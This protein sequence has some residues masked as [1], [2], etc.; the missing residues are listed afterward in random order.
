[1]V[2]VTHDM[3]AVRYCDRVITL[4]DGTIGSIERT[5]RRAG[6]DEGTVPA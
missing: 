1:M 5:E 4:R 2:M 3:G 6:L